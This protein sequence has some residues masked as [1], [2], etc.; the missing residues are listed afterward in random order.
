VT[1]VRRHDQS[2]DVDQSREVRPESGRAI[3]VRIYSQ[4]HIF[5]SESSIRPESHLLTGV[6]HVTEV[7]HTTGVVIYLYYKH[8]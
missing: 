7:V 6:R 3:G 5:Q 1:R 2:H 8:A 4:S